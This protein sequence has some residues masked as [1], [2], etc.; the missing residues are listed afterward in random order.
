MIEGKIVR[1][2][3]P[4]VTAKG[5]DEAGLYDVVEVGSQKLAGEII[6]MDSRGATIQVY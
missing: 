6:R 2:S 4:V 3:G 5:L 1:I